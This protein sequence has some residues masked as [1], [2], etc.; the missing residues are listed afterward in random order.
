MVVH[1]T[2]KYIGGH[3]DVVGGI[4]I[5]NDKEL[6][7]TIKFHQNAVGGVP[8]PHDAWLTMRGAKTLAIR[9]REHART[10]RRSLNF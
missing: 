5:T 4:A 8:G 7:D 2:T 9:M 3:S 6:Y 1:S 10:R